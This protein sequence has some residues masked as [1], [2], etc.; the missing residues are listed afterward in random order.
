VVA[1]SLVIYQSYAGT[2]VKIEQTEYL[3]VQS[4]NIL[5]I[6]EK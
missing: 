1:V 5:A 6:L 3:L 4:K 2:K